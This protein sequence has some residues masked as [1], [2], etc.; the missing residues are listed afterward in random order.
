[1]DN[2]ATQ[3]AGS[4]PPRNAAAAA[5]VPS[6]SANTSADN[7]LP[8]GQESHTVRDAFTRPP[9]AIMSRAQRAEQDAVIDRRLTPQQAA[10]YRAERAAADA[11]AAQAGE[12]IG[13]TGAP[14]PGGSV[15]AAIAPS[16]SSSAT[17]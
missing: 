12:T 9:G 13:D 14:N 5:A 10:D 17:K 7:I 15:P 16:S 1:M 11:A 3:P 2:K 6:S 4:T 8:A